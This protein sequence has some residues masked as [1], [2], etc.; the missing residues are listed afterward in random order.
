MSVSNGCE[1]NG[2]SVTIQG[3]ATAIPESYGYGD[4]GVFRVTFPGTPE[5]ECPGPN[6]IVQDYDDDEDDG[7]ALVQAS[8]FTT[9][10]VLSREQNPSM[11]RIQVSSIL[12]RMPLLRGT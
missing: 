2:Q 10:F 12:W 8:N 5:P 6:Y 7:Y 9:L 11:R 1:L 3:T 4:E